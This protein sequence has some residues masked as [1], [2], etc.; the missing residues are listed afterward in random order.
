MITI[1]SNDFP[2]GPASR[3][4]VTD[5][6]LKKRS[7]CRGCCNGSNSRNKGAQ[8][9]RCAKAMRRYAVRALVGLQGR[10]GK[11][12]QAHSPCLGDGK[13]NVRAKAAWG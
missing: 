13:V 5:M 2:I 8:Q 3:L 11:V 6:S 9:F 12:V 10:R 1:T 7:Y 4:L